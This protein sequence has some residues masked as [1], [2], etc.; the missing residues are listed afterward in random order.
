[1]L[2]K[3]IAFDPSIE[4]FITVPRN[5][6]IELADIVEIGFK[7]TFH[8]DERKPKNIGQQTNQSEDRFIPGS[9]GQS[10]QNKSSL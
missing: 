6:S 7:G 8:P 2:P 3:K 4:F 1:M 10:Y 5:E 9:S